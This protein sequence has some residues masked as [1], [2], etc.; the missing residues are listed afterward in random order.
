MTAGPLMV[1]I[2]GTQLQADERERLLHPS[3]SG[4]ILFTR[5]FESSEQLVDLVKVLREVKTPRLLIAV[6][7]EGGRVQ[8]FRDDFFSLPPLRNLGRAYAESEKQGLA[9][10]QQHGYLMASEILSV[11]IDISFAPVLDVDKG[12]SEVIGER[13]FDSDPVIIAKLAQAYIK[14][15]HEAGMK[16]TGKHFPGHGSVKA[17]SHVALPVDERLY[18]EIFEHDMWPFRQL[19]KQNL[20]AVMVS[21]VIYP[22]VDQTP[23]GFSKTWVTDELKNKL[24][25]TGMV[26]SDDITMQAA[27]SVGSHTQR[28]RLAIAAGCD[29]VIT[30]N[31]AQGRDEIIDQLDVVP[32]TILQ[33]K[34][35]KMYGQAPFAFNTR[36]GNSRWVSAHDTIARWCN[37]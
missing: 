29:C 14:G 30:C 13:A 25:F 5:N 33:A 6:D 16:A 9:L 2:E 17:D 31:D 18:S 36:G 34:I 21:H 23:A 37:A 19:I 27:A 12:I 24:G 1:D 8:R 10:A 20:D 15:M 32:S 3:V 4:I 22:D 35:D 28:A 7:Q 11:G 26:F